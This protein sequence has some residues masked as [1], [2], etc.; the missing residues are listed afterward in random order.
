M[1][2]GGYPLFSEVQDAQ[3]VARWGDADL[4][5]KR[6][7]IE[8]NSLQPLNPAA[9]AA[10]RAGGPDTDNDN[11][12]EKE[13]VGVD[14]NGVPLKSSSG[15]NKAARIVFPTT[16]AEDEDGVIFGSDEEVLIVRACFLHNN[17]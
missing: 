14:D 17:S 8:V 11:D 4:V 1:G 6:L 2:P 10:L 5:N 3:P 15:N 7:T 16:V 12:D 13:N 9:V